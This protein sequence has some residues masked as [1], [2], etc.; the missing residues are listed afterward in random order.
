M[1]NSNSNPW[2]DQH[3]AGELEFTGGEY[4][5]VKA[6]AIVSSEYADAPEPGTCGI[7]GETA[8]YRATVGAVQCPSCGAIR[9]GVWVH[10]ETGA[11]RRTMNATDLPNY[12]AED[13]W[14][15]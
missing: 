3:L 12:Y 2:I 13:R 10:R 5:A 9:Y 6:K 1:N 7:C 11:V 15:S 14:A 4:T 8:H